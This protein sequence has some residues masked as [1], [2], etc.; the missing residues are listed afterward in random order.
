V[1]LGDGNPVEADFLG[2]H[3]EHREVREVRDQALLPAR[4]VHVRVRITRVQAGP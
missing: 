3:R 4:V 2:E 1:V